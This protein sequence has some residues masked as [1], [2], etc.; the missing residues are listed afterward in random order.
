VSAETEELRVHS[1]PAFWWRREP[2]FLARLLWPLSAIYGHM[3]A[4]RMRRRAPELKRLPVICIG[5]FTLGGGGKTPTA[6]AA[7]KLLK[8]QGAKPVLLSRG[9]GGRERG[10][11]QV[12]DRDH[13]D[14]VGDEP[15]LLADAAPT[16]VARDRYAGALAAAGRGA[17]II[18]MDD[19]F[20]SPALHKDISI[21]A[22]DAAVGIGNG[23]T[24]PSGPLRAPLDGQLELADALVMVGEGE[25]GEQIAARFKAA[26]K[27]VFRATYQAISKPKWLGSGPLIAFAGI[28]R[29][30]KF[31]ATLE[32]LGA[33]L[34]IRKAFPDHHVFSEADAAKLLDLAETNGAILATTEK[35]R[36]RLRGST[37]ACGSLYAVSKALPIALRLDDEKA[38]GRLLAKALASKSF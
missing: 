1:E 26:G 15:L 36:A 2:N 23:M 20:Q 5:N 28:A 4:A 10:P 21:I 8:D 13:A 7:A 6:I 30:E 11:H 29:P 25:A 31:F 12:N 22:L 27:L 14:Q 24:I 17:D 34:G 33:Q 18:I 37:G 32:A 3:A 16:I 9:Y 38:F 35:D 19:G